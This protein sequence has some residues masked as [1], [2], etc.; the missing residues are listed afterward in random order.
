MEN[1]YYYFGDP[2]QTRAGFR[3]LSRPLVV[4]CAGYIART[5]KLRSDPRTRPDWFLRVMDAGMQI[6]NDCMTITP[7]QFILLP[8]DEPHFAAAPSG[9]AA[10]YWLHVTGCGVETLIRSFGIEPG[11][12]YDIPQSV[13]AAVK[14]DFANLFHEATLCQPGYEEMC[15]AISQGILI[16]LGR[17]HLN[18]GRNDV[19]AECRRRLSASVQQMHFHYTSNLR[20][21][22]LAAMEHLSTSRYREIF[23]LAFGVSPSEYLMRLRIFYARELL[24]TT[25]LSVTEIAGACGFD[26]VMYFCRLFHKKTGVSPGNYRKQRWEEPEG[27]ETLPFL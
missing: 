8:P 10:F 12:V 22:E 18:A 3:D 1:C 14:Q 2:V 25:E 23:R 17:G 4:N 21:T 19:A 7:R 11:R 6:I 9:P 5:K 15:G 20:I 16:K 24:G 13:M 26:D 27:E